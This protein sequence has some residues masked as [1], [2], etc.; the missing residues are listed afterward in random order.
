MTIRE[1]AGAETFP[2]SELGPRRL[3]WRVLSDVRGEEMTAPR[4]LPQN[5]RKGRRVS[6]PW[7]RGRFHLVP[8]PHD[9]IRRKG[10]HGQTSPAH[11]DAAGAPREGSGRRIPPLTR[12]ATERGEARDRLD[13]RGGE[14]NELSAVPDEKAQEADEGDA[15]CG[16]HT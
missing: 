13:R 16:A 5:H 10:K 1:T 15:G 9:D 12:V 7:L 11:T 4:S 6:Q 3:P 8:K 2:R 14:M